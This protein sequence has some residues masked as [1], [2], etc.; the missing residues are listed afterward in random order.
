[1]STRSPDV[2]AVVAQPPDGGRELGLVGR[3]R[4]P[5]ARRDDL[6]RVERQ[7]AHQ[8]ERAAGRPAVARPERSGRVLDEG[9]LLRDRGLQ[10]L[11]RDGAPEEVHGEHGARP[12]GDGRGDVLGAGEE[13]VRVDVHEHGA[14]A[15]QLDDVRGGRERVRGHDHLVAGPDP[16]R[17]H[18]EVE[19]GCPGRDRD[20]VRRADRLGHRTLE[21][22]DLRPHGQLAALEHLGDRREL[23]LADVGPARRIGSWVTR[24]RRAVPGTTRSCARGPRRARLAPRTRAARAP[25]RRSGSG[26]RRRC[27]RAARSG[28]R[29]GRPSAA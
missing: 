15:A 8:P 14:A 13:G 1:M 12:R 17:E 21:R 23:G 4:A 2:D 11:P 10:L 5:L 22:G 28:S 16:E 19:R 7:A 18:R 9:D 25:S 24:P 20:R 6:A 3:H 27:S 29:R 26:A